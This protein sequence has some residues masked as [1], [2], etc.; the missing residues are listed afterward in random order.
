[1]A[2]GCVPVVISKGGQPEIVQHGMNGFLWEKQEE[3]QACTNRLIRDGMLM[4]A[5]SQQAVKDSRKYSKEA[6][7][8]RLHEL[9][10]AYL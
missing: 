10:V 5:L 3:L 6:F 7:S 4:Q 9:M 2:A 8:N 1:M